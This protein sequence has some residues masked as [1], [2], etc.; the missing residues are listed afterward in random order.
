M[1]QEIINVGTSA[2]DGTGDALRNAFI[3]TN[4]NFTEV[5]SAKI[6]GSGT[7]NYVSKFTASGSIGNSQIFD[8][9]TNIGIGTSS[10]GSLLHLT[11]TS[12]PYIRLQTTNGSG[13]L[14]GIGIDNAY[15]NGINFSE[16]GVADARLFIATGG[17]VGIGTTSPGAKLH[18]SGFGIFDDGT[19]GRLTFEN[20][21]GQNDI[22]STTTAFGGWKNLRLSSNEL[23]LS[24]GGT[25][26][27]MRI[28]SSG[29]VGIGTTSPLYKTVIQT[30]NQ[31]FGLVVTTNSNDTETGL[32]IKPDHTNSIV[33]LHA[34]GGTDKAFAFLTGNTE[35]MRI[36]SSG[37]VYIGKTSGSSK[38]GI[39]GLPTS[40]TGLS[41][42]DIWN[43][44]GTLKIV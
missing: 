14:W 13:K 1:A 11:S 32:Y 9:G 16:I 3:K 41:S 5:Y 25:T 18:V 24:S 19:N 34:S 10:P 42:G 17:N 28:T 33:N 43:D 4:N 8:N 37:N 7:T 2:N 15:S 6:G 22:Y 38:F 36:T 23:I 26:E 39:S 44:G 12:S 27:R 40:S 20:A 21:S 35:R 30:A 29:N 31:T